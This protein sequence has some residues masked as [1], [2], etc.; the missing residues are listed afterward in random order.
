MK[1]IKFSLITLAALILF[2]C[3]SD[4]RQIE[5]AAYGYL[6][7]TGN[8]R[9]DEAYPY[10]TKETRETTLKYITQIILPMTDSNYLKSNVPATIVI[11]SIIYQQDTAFAFYTKT[12]PIKTLKNIVC[13][14]R[15]DGK[16]LVDVPLNLSNS[17]IPLPQLPTES[18]SVATDSVSVASDL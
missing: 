12:T 5:K 9:I 7:A 10:A 11:D 18:D 14:I 16:W 2:S 17:P 8:Y 3:N 4:K 13:L 15:E 1:P 6:N